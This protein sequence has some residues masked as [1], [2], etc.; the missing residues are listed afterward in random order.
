LTD[1]KENLV[2]HKKKAPFQQG[3]L[4]DQK[5]N[6]VF[7]GKLTDQEQNLVFQKKK[8]PFQKSQG[9]LTDQ[10]QNHVFQGRLTD[11]EQNHVF[12]KKK[13]QFQ[14]SQ[15]GHTCPP[16]VSLRGGPALG[17]VLKR[18]IRQGVIKVAH[19]AGALPWQSGQSGQC[20]PLQ[21]Q[22]RAMVFQKNKEPFQKSLGCEVFFVMACPG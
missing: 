14:K 8:A 21:R 9:K 1:Q 10:K 15:G 16:M 20:H 6:H 11:Q 13:A 18:H 3:K 4:T 22:T 12:Q 19:R 17:R 2:F 7:Q 5:Q